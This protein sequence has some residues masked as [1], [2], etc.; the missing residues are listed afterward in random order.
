M[1]FP[2]GLENTPLRNQKDI[3]KLSDLYQRQND[4]A[5]HFH[6]SKNFSFENA[7]LFQFM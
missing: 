7:V 4:Y 1:Y 3:L 5:F 2:E 6:M